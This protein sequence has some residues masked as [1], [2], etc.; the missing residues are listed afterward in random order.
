[1]IIGQKWKVHDMDRPRPVRVTPGAPLSGEPPS[2]AIVPAGNA[3]SPNLERLVAAFS[4]RP[5]VAGLAG[6][7]IVSP[8]RQADI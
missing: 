4:G 7:D 3:F 2:D 1:M 6:V 8:M 5:E